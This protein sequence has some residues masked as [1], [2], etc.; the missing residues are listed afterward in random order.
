MTSLAAPLFVCLLAAGSSARAD[1]AP[2]AAAPVAAE[3]AAVAPAPVATT[4]E[5]APVETTKVEAPPVATTAEAAPEA[6]AYVAPAEDSA[7]TLKVYGDTQF[8]ANNGPSIKNSFQA[9][10]L[11]LFFTSEVGRLTFLSEVYLESG[12]ENEFGI[13]A[14]RLQLTYLFGNMLRARLGRSH[15]AFGYYNDTFHHGN[16][17]E[18]TTARPLGVQFE[19]E[20]GL[21]P[22]HLVGAGIDGT[23]E[24]G[25][26]GSF[27]YDAE[28][29]NGRLSDPSK[30]AVFEAGKNRKLV[31]VRLRWLPPVEG[32]TLGINGLYDMIP[33][34][35]ASSANSTTSRPAIDQVILG[36]HA[37]YMAN[38]AHVLAEV[39]AVNN[40]VIGGDT[41]RTIGSFLELGYAIGA[42]TPYVRP[43]YI[44]LPD[45]NDPYFQA[46]ATSSWWGTTS[47]LDIRAGVR[48]MVSPQIA[49][50]FE[51]DR[52]MRDDI[53]LNTGTAKVAFGF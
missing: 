9:A 11:D 20:G 16:L 31:N 29:G 34:A 5:A 2:A 46:N 22:A 15:T 7:V 4:T 44:K 41:S 18:L 8:S 3:P 19:D 23:F 37:A 52:T 53:N 1:E 40:K 28:V 17:F 35:L 33:E 21:T 50:K 32:L 51:Y 45:S 43:E 39:Y 36:A 42:F 24:A 30:V 26:A 25:S 47:V 49:M 10:H 27:H 6:A 12:T 38:G 13:D 48:W 14:E